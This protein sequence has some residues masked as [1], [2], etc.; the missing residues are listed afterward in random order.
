MKKFLVLL[1]LV[2]GSV[3]FGQ[4]WMQGQ[5]VDEFGLPVENGAYL[6]MD[7]Y[8]DGKMENSATTT[9]TAALNILIS[10][11]DPEEG[12][13]LRILNYGYSPISVI[14][15]YKTHKIIVLDLE[16]RV[17]TE[18]TGVFWGTPNLYIDKEYQSQ[19]RE[20][21][22]KDVMIHITVNDYGKTTYL[23]TLKDIGNKSV[24]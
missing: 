11:D 14:D 2:C 7:E 9:G 16:T 4:S 21:L 13:S 12:I 6:K 17:K 24:L 19:F 3:V 1:M 22:K 20:L 10:L 5:F 8:T 18:I 23:F 15:K